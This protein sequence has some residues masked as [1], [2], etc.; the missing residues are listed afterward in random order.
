M[1]YLV[2][3][4]CLLSDPDNCDT[5]RY[6]LYEAS[7]LSCT[8]AGQQEIPKLTSARPGVF[9]KEWSCETEPERN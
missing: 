1:T 3:T 2:L 9:V 7:L 5:F 8:F 4:L 6:R